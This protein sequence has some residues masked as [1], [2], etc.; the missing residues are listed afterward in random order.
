MIIVPGQGFLPGQHVGFAA[1]FPPRTRRSLPACSRPRSARDRGVGQVTRHLLTPASQ[2]VNVKTRKR[3]VA[4]PLDPA[5]FASDVLTLF[6][7]A[8]KDQE[9]VPDKLAAAGKA[10]D[11]TNLDFSRYGSTLFEIYFAGARMGVGAKLADDT[12]QQLDWNVCAQTSVDL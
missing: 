8:C 7:E 12:K 5:K 10:L 3:N 11:T 9:T 4:V 2:G 1:T 6:H